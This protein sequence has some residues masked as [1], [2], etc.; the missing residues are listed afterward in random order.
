MYWT[1]FISH[2]KL[3][4]WRTYIDEY[5][6]LFYIFVLCNLF[7]PNFWL[8]KYFI[9]RNKLVVGTGKP[10]P[11]VALKNETCVSPDSDWFC[12]GF[13]VVWVSGTCQPGLWW[14]GCWRCHTS[15]LNPPLRHCHRTVPNLIFSRAVPKFQGYK[16]V[17]NLF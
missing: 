12:N 3:Y 1:I 17:Q 9:Y 5:W 10:T 4:G 16:S 2:Q 8:N 7:A 13:C 15:R 11:V 6:L 14:P